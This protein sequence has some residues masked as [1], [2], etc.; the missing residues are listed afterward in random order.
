[1]I[2]NVRKGMKVLDEEVFAPVVTVSSYRT[3]EEAIELVNDSKYGLQ[4]GIYTSDL[5][6]SYKI[7]YL[8][9]VGGV[10]INDT[11]CYRVDQMPYGGVKESGNGKEGP[12]Y[13]IQDL[14][15]TVTVV[16]NLED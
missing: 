12:S 16:V 9:E 14:V 10:I 6:L 2:T 3:I 8:L 5:N 7:P 15:E 1:M 13:A 4:A 11:C